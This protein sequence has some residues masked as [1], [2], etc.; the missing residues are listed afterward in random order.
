MA[1]R[2]VAILFLGLIGLPPAHPG[3]AEELAERIEKVLKEPGY[4][5]G[6]WG[7]LIV[8]RQTDEVL[9]ERA[10]DER[11]RP[12][13][14]TKLFSTAAALIDLG[15]DFR[16][17]TPVH[18]RGEV[19]ESGV[20][21]GDLI[22][23]A[24]GDLSLGGRTGPDGSMLYTDS[25]HSYAGGHLK[26]K[27][28]EADP[29]AGLDSLARQIQAAGIREVRGEVIIDDRLFP[30]APSTGSGPARVTPIILNDNIIDVVLTP[31]AEPG[32]PADCR[33]VPETGYVAVDNQVQTAAEGT[34][35]TVRV[36]SAGPRGIV[37]RGRLPVG[38]EPVVKIH[39]VED[40]ASFARAVFIEVL[41]SY[42]VRVAASPLDHNDVEKLPPSSEVAELPR[43]AEY[44][45]PPFREYLRVILK[46]S[47][48]LHAS[49]LP[50]LLGVRQ[51]RPTLAAGLRREGELLRSLGLDV[52]T[53]S[54]GGGAGGSNADLVTPRATV[55]LLKAMAARPDFEAYEAALPVLGRDGTLAKAVGPDSPARGH[56]R[57]KTGT[58]WVESGLTGRA[59]MTSKAL[60]GYMETASSRK[61]IFA[62]FLNDV[63]LDA[64][65]DDVSDAT[66]AAG[67][68]LG[69][70]CEV[71]Y[72]DAR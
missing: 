61:L 54:F 8:D 1:R 15:P 38:H 10:P 37:V 9:Y 7:L 69:R 41:R 2:L 24:S 68:L 72:D 58:Y 52:D 67:R 36:E 35:P 43:V 6:R 23:V 50:V 60:A 19:D 30:P 56:V 34:E 46:V 5:H 63:P 66:A 31:G 59:V 25:D 4:Q 14:V 22:L 18:R 11:F 40:P 70:L 45:S 39:E 48:N 57:A 16:F 29:R 32:E 51:G 49:A 71:V 65:S 62:F 27:L 26:A 47:Q 33:L 64:P 13:S 12:A 44:I 21:K 28:V 53:I 42:G 17:T 3:R 20:L 55:Q